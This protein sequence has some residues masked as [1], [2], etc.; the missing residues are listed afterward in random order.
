MLMLRSDEFNR[1]SILDVSSD[2]G[3][4][5][6]DH[7]DAIDLG[8]LILQYSRPTMSGTRQLGRA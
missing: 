2:A 4:C 5:H 6:T 1:K 7:D 3:R 8:A